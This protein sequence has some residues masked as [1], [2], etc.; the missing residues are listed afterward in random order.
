MVGVRLINTRK[1]GWGARIRTWECRYQ[2]PVPYHLATPQLSGGHS[3]SNFGL[4][5]PNGRGL[6]GSCIF[7]T[8]VEAR[9][10]LSIDIG[11]MRVIFVF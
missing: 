8:W 5:H 11:Q 7:S 3:Q 10:Q 2:K 9:M 1:G 4:Q 6:F